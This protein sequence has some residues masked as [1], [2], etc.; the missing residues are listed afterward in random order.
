MM[1]SIGSMTRENT[2]ADLGLNATSANVAVS[3]SIEGCSYLK[4]IAE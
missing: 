3:I 2:T 4:E 1:M